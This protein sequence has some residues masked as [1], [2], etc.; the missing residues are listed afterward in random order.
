[1]TRQQL[2][3]QG[4]ALDKQRRRIDAF[5]AKNPLAEETYQYA[6][7][8]AWS[9]ACNFAMKSCYAGAVLALHDIEGYGTQRNARFLR[10][11]DRYIT[12][13]LSSEEIIDEALQK[14]GVAIDFREAFED[15]RVQ[16]VQK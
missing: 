16:E 12:E 1:M 6:Y 11:M 13:S 8:R 3:A 14:A 7:R 4:R 9:D 2:R 10:L 5:C 15:D